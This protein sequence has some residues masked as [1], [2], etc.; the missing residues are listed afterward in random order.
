VRQSR[1]T[2]LKH[3]CLLVSLMGLLTFLLWLPTG[4]R[5]ADTEFFDR[6]E[7]FIDGPIADILIADLDLDQLQDIF[8]FYHQDNPG[9]NGYRISFFHQDPR[10]HFKNTIKQSWALESG[11]GFF[12][13]ADVT[14]DSLRELVVLSRGGVTYYKM[15]GSVFDDAGYP[16]IT[17]AV[18][19][20]VPPNAMMSLDF[21]WPLIG[22][23]GEVVSLPQV[24]HLELWTPDD[25]GN[26]HPADSL[27]CRSIIHPPVRRLYQP[28]NLAGGVSGITYALPAPAH[29]IT[30]ASTEIFLSSITGIKGFRRDDLS[31]LDFSEGPQVISADAAAP[32]FSRGPFGSGVL[33]RDINGDG[34]SDLLRWQAH[35]G[36]TEA[37]TEIEI[38]YGPLSAQTSM[39]PHHR[40]TVDNVTAYPMLADLDGDQRQ[41]IVICAIELGT[42]TAA[43]MIVVK[44]ANLYLLAYRQRPDNSFGENADERLKIDCRLD[45]E[46][47]ELLSRVPARFVD[48]LNSDGLADFVVCPGE[49]E[50]H[51]YLGQEGRLLP[52]EE[53]LVIDC[54]SPMAV[55]PTDLDHDRKTDLVVLHHTK[56]YHVHKVTVFIT[57]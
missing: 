47:P 9:E 33:T 11:G 7:L 14:G 52:R 23:R 6:H 13:V 30:P 3:S 45:T 56:P 48:D 2:G 43:K 44:N 28:E 26:Y 46:S 54:D 38:F 20:D 35:G 31:L 24:D 25:Q 4:S 8:V 40:I 39:T 16:L 29:E 10:D 42:I 50:F 5:A 37:R 51:V 34:S 17:P 55:Y 57:K 41:D 27:Q 18:R 12:D 21:C 32:F 49:D 22:G 15:A 1:T 19:P 36:I 53:T